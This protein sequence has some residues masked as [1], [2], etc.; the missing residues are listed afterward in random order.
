MADPATAA[1]AVCYGLAAVAAHGAILF[2]PPMVAVALFTQHQRAKAEH[3]KSEQARG[4][5][6]FSNS[7]VIACA[8]L[9]AR[10]RRCWAS[11]YARFTERSGSS[12]RYWAHSRGRVTELMLHIEGEATD[13]D[14]REATDEATD[15]DADVD[16]SAGARAGGES[17]KRVG[18]A[19]SPSEKG[20]KT[21][22]WSTT[23]E[24]RGRMSWLRKELG[25]DA[26]KIRVYGSGSIQ[27]LH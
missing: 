16:S 27:V 18:F 6:Q 14:A 8:S 15:E 10:C 4:D 12:S 1:V 3:A 22:P 7:A 20:S 11:E 9:S 2:V 26:D 13:E 25:A 24:K 5:E 17:T 23:P 19:P 21:S